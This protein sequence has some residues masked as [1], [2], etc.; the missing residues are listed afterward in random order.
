MICEHGR[1]S[2]LWD[3]RRN[4][5]AFAEEDLNGVA[6]TECLPTVRRSS[7]LFALTILLSAFLLFQVQ[8]IISKHI[9]PWFGGTAE[10]WTA[11]MLVFQ[12]VLLAGYVYSH[13]IVEK[14]T[15]KAQ[16]QVHCAL[17]SVAFLVVF[18][19]SVAWPS[20]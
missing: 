5:A 10:V 1:Q 7:G 8:L 4:C 3:T 2:G 16:R 14:L 19:L 20:G 6:N 17:L 9:L 15:A 12:M 13:V 18:V 11:C